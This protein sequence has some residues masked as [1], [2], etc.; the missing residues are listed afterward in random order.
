MCVKGVDGKLKV[1]CDTVEEH[2]LN[3]YYKYSKI[4][5]VSNNISRN[6]KINL[7][8][9][10]FDFIINGKCGMKN[11]FINVFIVAT[12]ITAC[13]SDV[14]GLALFFEALYWLF[15]KVK[16]FRT[17]YKNILKIV[18]KRDTKLPIEYFL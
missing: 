5:I 15:K 18:S 4:L 1:I 13:I 12:L 11:K 6:A 9:I 7:L 14:G 17:L 10:T 3:L 2:K 8:K 16:I